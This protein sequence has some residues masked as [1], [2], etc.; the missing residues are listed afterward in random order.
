MGEIVGY[1]AADFLLQYASRERRYT[2]VPA[3]TWDAVLSHISDPADVTRLADSAR[4]RLLYRYAISLYR[5]NA[6]ADD[7]YAAEQLAGLLESAATW[8]SCRIP[9]RCW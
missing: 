8:M 6:D 1:M 9:G 5:R 4:K 7:R 3:S 2:R